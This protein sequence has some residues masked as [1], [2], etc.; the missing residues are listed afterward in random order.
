MN[1][2]AA[3]ATDRNVVLDDAQ[4]A[5]V[6]ASFIDTAV[7]KAQPRDPDPGF[8]AAYR[9][10]LAARAAASQRV[11][12]AFQTASIEKILLR[13]LLLGSIKWDPIGL[14]FERFGG[15]PSA[16][17]ARASVPEA[18]DLSAR[19]TA[20]RQRH[21]G[22]AAAMHVNLQPTVPSMEVEGRELR[23][24]LYFWSPAAA[25]CGVVVEC[26]GFQPHAPP[27][28]AQPL[29]LPAGVS[30]LRLTG[31]DMFRDPVGAVLQLLHAADRLRRAT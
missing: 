23:V 2:E 7:A 11:V 30:P 26:A 8:A 28:D 13:W 1:D 22:G 3:G 31:I 17:D 5:E 18:A 27:A 25:H 19:E 29:A 4:F 10:L 20:F 24:D 15:G 14:V 16:D 12:D 21:F 6:L 9:D